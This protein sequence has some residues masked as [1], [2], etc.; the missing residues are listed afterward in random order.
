VAAI[1]SSHILD[2]QYSQDFIGLLAFPTACI[3]DE[4]VAGQASM[5]LCRDRQLAGQ[6][7]RARISAAILLI[8]HR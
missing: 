1:S 7:H 6:P 2:G 5:Q 4:V 3:V 8:P